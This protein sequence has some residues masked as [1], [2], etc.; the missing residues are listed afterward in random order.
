M[1]RFTSVLLELVLLALAPSSLSAQ[2]KFVVFGGYSYLRP[3]VTVAEEIVTCVGPVFCPPP[4]IPSFV[5]NRQNLN[6][7]ELSAT[8]R[9]LPFLGI[10]ADFSGHY[11]SA[12][13]GYP[14]RAHQYTYLFGPEISLPSRVS[15]FAHVLF[16]GT[17]QSVIPGSFAIPVSGTYT[18]IASSTDSAFATSFGAGI[19]LKLVPHLWIR[20]IQL[21]YLITRLGSN[22]QNQARVSAGVVFHF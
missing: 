9:F 16:G 4:S 13:S 10:A 5:T 22:T 1:L 2:D 8:Y 14:S 7:W 3:P 12:I 17:H 21:D 11:G 6:G 15:P 19:D 20:P 18:A